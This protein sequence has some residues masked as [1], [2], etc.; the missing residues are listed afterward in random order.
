M[1]PDRR[2]NRRFSG[3][4]NAPP[5]VATTRFV[6]RVIRSNSAVFGITKR[7]LALLGEDL[8]NGPSRSR[9]DDLI[10]IDENPSEPIG[11]DSPGR[12]L[13]GPHKTHEIDIGHPFMVPL[14]ENM[15]DEL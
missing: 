7:V 14:R 2:I 10:E 15:N 4:E 6:R 8:P 5:P 13:S 11:D 12:G 9:F 1:P 3:E